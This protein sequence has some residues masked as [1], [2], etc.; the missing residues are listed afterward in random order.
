MEKK[1]DWAEVITE[2]F[3]QA[4]EKASFRRAIAV[5]VEPV[6]QLERWRVLLVHGNFKGKG[7]SIHFNGWAGYEG[8]ISS[9]I[10]PWDQEKMRGISRSGRIYELVGRPGSDVDADYVIGRWLDRNENPKWEDITDNYV[11]NSTGGL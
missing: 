11:T 4:V 7:D 9:P 8:R 3:L 6:T 5:E 10:C 2:E 1:P